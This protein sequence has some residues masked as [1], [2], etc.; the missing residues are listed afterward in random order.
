MVVPLAVVGV[1]AYRTGIDVINAANRNQVAAAQ[2]TV[3]QLYTQRVSTIRAAITQVGADPKFQADLAAG[4][5]GALQADLRLATSPATGLL[6]FLILAWPDQP[7]V[8]VLG[9]PLYLPGI[10]APTVTDLVTPATTT[11]PTPTQLLVAKSIVPITTAGSQTVVATLIGGLYLDNAFADSFTVGQKLG[12]T[13][14]VNG[15][16]VGSS[17]QVPVQTA[18]WPM[19][20]TLQSGAGFSSTPLRTTMLHKSVDALVAPLTGGVPVSTGAVVVTGGIAPPTQTGENVA[21]ILIVL[22]LAALAAGLVGYA[23]A[24]AIAGPLRQLA[25]GA[26]AISAGN[27][28]TRIEVRSADEVGQLA[29]AFNEMTERLAA[30]VAQLQDSREELRRSLTR[31]GDTLRSTHDLDKILQ[32]VLD[33]S[34]DTLRASAGVLFVVHPEGPFDGQ[35]TVAAG[36]GVPTENLRL[37]AGEGIAGA[38]ALSG[39]PLRASLEDEGRTVLPPA[40][41]VEPPFESAVWV[42]VFAQGRIFAVLA[43]YDR[44]DGVAFAERDLDTLSSLADQAGV[45][46]DNVVLHEEAQRLAITDSMTG[47]WNHRYFQLRFDQEMDRSARFRRP[48]CL[49]LCDIDDFKA[50]NDT[51]GHPVGD[52]VLMELARRVRSEIRDI[53][54]LARYGG[55]EFVLILPETDTDGG[56][57]VAEKIRKRVAQARFAREAAVPVTISVGLASFPKAG[58]DQTALLRAA[59]VALY[60]AKARGKNRTVIYEA[61]EHRATSVG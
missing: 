10:N 61:E 13:F 25:A 18:A 55:E 3:M 21:S 46:I 17:V 11:I 40:A 19:P 22:A 32:V 4:D 24:H 59:D 23:V 5:R 37:G 8:S 7:P 54:V 12:V 29:H 14:V 34:I 48:F 52:A 56:F 27:Y 26:D 43:L 58:T 60:E 31:F 44:E 42:P 41:A 50:I 57:L 20:V 38:V 53:D 36:R 35:L 15:Q 2:P 6:N 33:T 47:I 16:A 49:L 51:F 39:E 28:E 1:L 30:H 9:Q 45:A